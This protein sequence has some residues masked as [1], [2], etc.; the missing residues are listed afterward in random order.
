MLFPPEIALQYSLASLAHNGWIYMEIRKGMPGLKQAGL[1]ANQ[2]LRTHLAKYGYHPMDR[3]PALWCHDTRPITFT[4]VVD[5]FGIKYVGKTHANHLIASIQ[6]LY[7]IS[8]DWTGS[9][10]CGLTLKWDYH[11]R[12]VDVSMP[13]YINAALHK[14]QHP[15]PTAPQDAPHN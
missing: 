8:L 2:R 3:T 7:S 13:G 6:A 4:L 9:L 10:Y 1:L 15:A 14:F 11:Q 5:G 12:T